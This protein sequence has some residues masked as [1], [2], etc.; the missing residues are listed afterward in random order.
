VQA[1]FGRGFGDS[2]LYYS[3]TSAPLLETRL[4]PGT[5]Q[6]YLRCL[7]IRQSC[8]C[9]AALDRPDRLETAPFGN[10]GTT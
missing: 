9:F 7:L 2:K 8:Y 10:R 3:Q 1:N 4:S 6:A 5:P